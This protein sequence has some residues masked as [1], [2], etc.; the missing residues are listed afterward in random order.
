MAR[1]MIAPQQRTE[2]ETLFLAGID[3]GLY[4]LGRAM[5]FAQSVCYGPQP[6]PT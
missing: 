1:N 5:N 4:L 2:L 3:A 6:E